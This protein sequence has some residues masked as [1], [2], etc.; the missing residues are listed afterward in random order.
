MSK[1]NQAS[2]LDHPDVARYLFHP[3]K[4][5]GGRLPPG[6]LELWTP[7]EKEDISINT[8]L[9]LSDAQKPHI[10]FFHGNGEI[11]SDY[12]E[13][14]PV[15]NSFGANLLVTDYRGYGKSNGFPGASAMLADAHAVFSHVCR[16]IKENERAGALWIMGRSLGSAPALELAS[17][18]PETCQG[19]I[20]E[21]GFAY[22]LDLLSRIGINTRLF[23][24]D[25]ATDR[26]NI[27]KIRRYAGPTLIIHAEQD[28]IIPV[29]HA[30]ALYD[31]S[32]AAIKKIHI[33]AG[34]D[35]N[36]IF[37]IAGQSYFSLIRDFINQASATART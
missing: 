5:P 11:A 26:I 19:L 4:D 9:F 17:C 18:Y 12:D 25:P 36:T 31:Q 16:W 22:T 23:Q 10:L 21:S 37:Y 6:A 24:Q 33:I 14:G 13:I 1:Q 20:I 15:Y 34:A 29:A 28:A 32:A 35:H 3:R 2:L 8:R 7:V 30:R 27:E